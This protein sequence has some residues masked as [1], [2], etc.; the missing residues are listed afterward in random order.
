MTGL[1]QTL[2][3]EARAF[4]RE[5]ERTM[6]VSDA[7]RDLIE[8]MQAAAPAHSK[9]EMAVVGYPNLE[10][11]TAAAMF[12]AS[13]VASSPNPRELLASMYQLSLLIL[14]AGGKT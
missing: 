4:G 12:A 3:A 10:K 1:S 2:E 6:I 8:N 7:T 9:L 5:V 14:D 13:T 11:T